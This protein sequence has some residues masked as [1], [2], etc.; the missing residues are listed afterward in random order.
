MHRFCKWKYYLSAKKFTLKNSF[1]VFLFTHHH[2]LRGE[3]SAALDIL[4][5]HPNIHLIEGSFTHTH[6]YTPAV[7]MYN[8]YS[9]LS[10]EPTPTEAIST[11]QRVA[12]HTYTHN[13]HLQFECIINQNSLLVEFSKATDLAEL[14]STVGVIKQSAHRKAIPTLMTS[15]RDH[16][17]PNDF[18]RNHSYPDYCL[19]HFSSLPDGASP[20][21][22]PW[23]TMP[24]PL[25]VLFRWCFPSSAETIPTLHSHS[26]NIQ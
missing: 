25:F 18:C 17:H 13:T 20:T 21:F 19:A 4:W 23:R 1:T 15:S 5:P 3:F 7:W 10:C 14:N 12:S 9:L 8:Q 2:H 16:S 22:Q 24:C 6:V 11:S 26:K